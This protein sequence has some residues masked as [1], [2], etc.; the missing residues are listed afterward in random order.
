MTWKPDLFT[1]DQRIAAAKAATRG[2]VLVDRLDREA[3]GAENAVALAYAYGEVDQALGELVEELLQ[4][5][6]ST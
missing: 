6:G 4:V 3:L 1:Y 5:P 2:Q